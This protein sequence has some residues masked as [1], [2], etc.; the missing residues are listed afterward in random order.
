LERLYRRLWASF[1]VPDDPDLSQHGRD[2]LHHVPPSGGVALSWLA[3]HLALPKSTTSVLVKDLERRGFLRRRRD[4]RDERRLAIV[5]TPKGHRRVQAGSVLDLPGLAAAMGR[6]TL[7][8]RGSLLDG[9]ERL[10]DEGEAL[11]GPK[12]WVGEGASPARP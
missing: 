11:A 8:E 6:L 5:L 3:H 1:R 7:D 12:P 4:V 10:A 9:L 2:L